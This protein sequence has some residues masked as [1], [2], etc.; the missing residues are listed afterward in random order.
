LGQYLQFPQEYHLELCINYLW[1]CQKF[2]KAIKTALRYFPKPQ[3]KFATPEK[4]F[5]IQRQFL[6]DNFSIPGRLTGFFVFAGKTSFSPW[7]GPTKRRKSR[8]PPGAKKL[9]SVG[10]ICLSPLLNG[11]P[12]ASVALCPAHRRMNEYDGIICFN[13]I[14]KYSSNRAGKK[15]QF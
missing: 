14:A 11:L 5:L 13:M 2:S 8:S 10:Q 7:S 9:P 6:E 1:R 3:I 15:V 12:Y 4:I